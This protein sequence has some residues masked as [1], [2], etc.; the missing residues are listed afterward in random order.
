MA[1]MT[2]EIMQTEEQRRAF[3]Q[4]LKALR[5]QQ[6]RTQKEI[7]GLI[8]LQLSQYNKYESGMHIPPA[9]KLIQLAELFTTSI[10]YL[11]LGSSD[12]QLPLSN[13]RLI[14][15]LKALE[16]CQPEEQ[17][18]VIKLIDAVIMKSRVESAMRPVEQEKGS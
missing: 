16:E 8:G 17:E 13:T 18:T 14:E 7:A 4:R 9:D 6:R 12:E 15:R 10:D 3:G 11:L 1:D 5:N 2:E